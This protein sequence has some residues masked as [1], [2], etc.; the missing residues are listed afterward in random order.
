MKKVKNNDWENESPQ[1]SP[2]PFK[3]NKSDAKNAPFSSFNNGKFVE[4]PKVENKKESFQA[5]TYFPWN[6]NFLWNYSLI[7]EFF[8]VV[9]DK[10]WVTP[11]IHGYVNWSNFDIQ[12]KLFS[13]ILIARR[14]RHFAG[15]RYLKRGL[16]EGGKVANFVEVEQILYS[17]KSKDDKPLI[18]SFVQV[19]GSVPLFW[20]QDPNPLV[21]KPDII[22]NTADV[23]YMATKRH[24]ADL[25]QQY[26]YPLIFF[27]LTKKGDSREVKLSDQYKHVINNII[28]S[29]LPE[30][31]G[32]GKL[33]NTIII[34]Y[35]HLDVKKAKKKK[36]LLQRANAYIESFLKYIGIFNTKLIKGSFL[37]KSL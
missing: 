28:N 10:Q 37:V 4:I 7:K 25:F 33:T 11:V 9:K 27:N 12:S 34:V 1:K 15:T 31:I 18:S 2:K 29:E 22:L 35:A 32:I 16:N 17:E 6:E 30:D 14:S 24:I 36:S 5:E 21:T 8:S 23:D 20:T 26:S 13:V 3:K 19:R